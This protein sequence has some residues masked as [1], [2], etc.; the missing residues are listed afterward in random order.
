[1]NV[2]QVLNREYNIRLCWLSTQCDIEG[3]KVAD[4]LA[5]RLDRSVKAIGKTIYKSHLQDN[6]EMYPLETGTIEVAAK[7]LGSY[8]QL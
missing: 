1:M 2:G 3:N 8:G 6:K 5:R 7:F 4:E